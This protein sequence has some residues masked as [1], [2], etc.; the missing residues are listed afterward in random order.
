MMKRNSV[1]IK[2]IIAKFYRDLRIED[3]SYE[4]DA[5]EWAGEAM[6]HIGSGVQFEA[7]HS[8]K[9]VSGYQVD[10]PINLFRLKE[11]YKVKFEGD[12]PDPLP[13]PLSSSNTPYTRLLLD[14]S[15]G[16]G[17]PREDDRAGEPYV[18]QGRTVH[19]SFKGGLV[20]IVYD[21]IGTDKEG[22]P[23]VPDDPSFKN[24]IIWYCTRQMIMGGWQHPDPNVNFPYA[25][26][27]WSRYCGQA[28][29]KSK[30]PSISEF[31]N[32]HDSWVSLLP[33]EN[34]RRN[35]FSASITRKDRGPY[36][37]PQGDDNNYSTY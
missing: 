14:E 9:T 33:R 10:L 24:A 31:Q 13:D 18:V 37:V 23:L 11:I 19:T 8:L 7:T 26:R 20:D 34:R 22:W 12:T 1:S 36:G 4:L 27:M 29:D 6:K 3:T 28:R 32:F 16:Q 15:G 35:D 21:A 25:D 2:N 30:M 17:L 5:V